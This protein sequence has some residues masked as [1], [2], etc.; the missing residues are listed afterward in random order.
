MWKTS[1]EDLLPMPHS[2]PLGTKI[3]EDE[4]WK[5]F[6]LLSLQHISKIKKS[7]VVHRSHI[8]KLSSRKMALYY[9]FSH[10]LIL[11]YTWTKYWTNGSHL[12]CTIECDSDSDS[13]WVF[14]QTWFLGGTYSLRHLW[15]TLSNDSWK[16]LSWRQVPIFPQLFCGICSYSTKCVYP[17]RSPGNFSDLS[18]FFPTRFRQIQ[19]LTSKFWPFPTRLWPLLGD[20]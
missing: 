5:S 13:E 15:I 8:L 18:D 19:S 7:N 20:A 9:H 1:T 10:S 3:K 2:L 4:I 6:F 11:G 16:L 14:F 12:K 17:Y